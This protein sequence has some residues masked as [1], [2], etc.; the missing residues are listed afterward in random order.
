M[1]IAKAQLQGAKLSYLPS[2]ALTPNGG[3]ASHGGLKITKDS[4]SY[5]IPA[6][7]SCT[8][9]P[10]KLLNNKRNAEAAVLQTE[11]YRQAVRSQIIS[12]VATVTT[13]SQCSSASYRFSTRHRHR[14]QENIAID[15]GFKRGR[16]LQRSGSG[17]EQGQLCKPARNHTASRGVASSGQQ[18]SL[19]LLN[20]PQQTWVADSSYEPS[21]PEYM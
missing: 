15:A 4:W 5:T 20:R 6:T 3:T 7:A 17:A 8:D 19:L 12:G 10:G 13:P 21:F 16:T 14:Q 18:H 1:D 11:A 2:V 9:V